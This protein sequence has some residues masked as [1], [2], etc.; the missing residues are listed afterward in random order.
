M[1]TT[2]SEPRTLPGFRDFLPKG[3]L[4]LGKTAIFI[5]AANI[6]Y[7]QQTLGWR[8]DYNKFLDEWKKTGSVSGAYFYTA[9]VS[10]NNKQLNF[11]KALKKIGY[12]VISRE[13]KV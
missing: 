6:F 9:V 3:L 10:T 2:I 11:F 13:V 8:L 7:S 12:E 4:P 1:K 5:D